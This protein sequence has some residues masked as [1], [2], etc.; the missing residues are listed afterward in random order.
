MIPGC[1]ADMRGF[2]PSLL[3]AFTPSHAREAV[4]SDFA[5]A[6]HWL[7]MNSRA[8]TTVGSLKRQHHGRR[9]GHH[10]IAGGRCSRRTDAA[11]RGGDESHYSYVL[12]ADYLVMLGGG[13]AAPPLAWAS[14]PTKL[15]RGAMLRGHPDPG[16]WVQ[17][18]SRPTQ[19]GAADGTPVQACARQQQ[20][21]RHELHSPAGSLLRDQCRGCMRAEGD[22][23]QQTL[24]GAKD[25]SKPMKNC[26]EVKVPFAGHVPGS[27]R[28]LHLEEAFTSANSVV[29]VYRRCSFPN[30]R[31]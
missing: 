20:A 30:R 7:R 12:G 2:C 24:L 28:L 22:A 18:W 10:V 1:N 29:R 31:K 19:P 16:M 13:Q 17:D 11:C 5:E 9:Y 14:H 26:F 3:I 15:L 23:M 27:Q 25:F 21:S 4:L 8:H 6:C